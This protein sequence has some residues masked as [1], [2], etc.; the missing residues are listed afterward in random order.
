MSQG[1]SIEY[2]LSQTETEQLALYIAIGEQKGGEWDYDSMKW[3]E[4][5]P[6]APV[7]AIP[8]AMKGQ[9]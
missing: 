5:P 9:S 1:V 4:P 2:A 8:A 7:F 6:P 3:A